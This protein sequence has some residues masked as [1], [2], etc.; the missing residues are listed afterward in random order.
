M[1]FFASASA[2]AR[3]TPVWRIDTDAGSF[4]VSGVTREVTPADG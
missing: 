4:Y 2:A 1:T 3:L